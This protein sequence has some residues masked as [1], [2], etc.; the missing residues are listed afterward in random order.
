MTTTS[1]AVI[2]IRF[3]VLKPMA[4]MSPE[5]NALGVIRAEHA[6]MPMAQT[7]EMSLEDFLLITRTI[8]GMSHRGKIMAA[9]NPIVFTA[10]TLPGLPPLSG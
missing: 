10:R 1:T 9:H 6:Q 8:N 2:M 3:T 5:I 7:L 4:R